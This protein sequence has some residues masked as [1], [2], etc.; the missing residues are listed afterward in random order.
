MDFCLIEPLMGVIQLCNVVCFTIYNEDKSDR[1]I[2]A[3]KLLHNRQSHFLANNVTAIKYQGLL[4]I[5]VTWPVH[6]PKS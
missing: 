4:K 2:S 3:I 1:N 6:P 5:K